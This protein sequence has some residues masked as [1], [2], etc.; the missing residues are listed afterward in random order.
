MTIS[1]DQIINITEYLF[2]NYNSLEYHDNGEQIVVN[3]IEEEDS[4]EFYFKYII[5]KTPFKITINDKRIPS[6]KLKKI[7]EILI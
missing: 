7:K 5:Y 6:N 2:P 1:N 3:V 4:I